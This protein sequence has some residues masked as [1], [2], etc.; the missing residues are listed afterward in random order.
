MSAKDDIKKVEP[1]L[2]RGR[3]SPQL[4]DEEAEILQKF[5][6]QKKKKIKNDSRVVRG[7]TK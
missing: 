3:K 1:A 6:Q 4:S 5:L 7:T 2:F